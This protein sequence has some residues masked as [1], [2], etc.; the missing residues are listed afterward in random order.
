VLSLTA[1]VPSTGPYCD[2]EV[3]Q[4]CNVST[5]NG[6]AGSAV[7][8]ATFH[9]A[10]QG[11]SIPSTYSAQD[12]LNILKATPGVPDAIYNKLLDPP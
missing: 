8:A 2:K 9:D 3:L 5:N 11:P 10:T 12:A 6:Q 1:S 7:H 4:I